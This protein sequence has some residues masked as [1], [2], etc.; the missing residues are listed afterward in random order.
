MKVVFGIL[1]ILFLAL[2][3]I[4]PLVEKYGKSYSQEEVSKISRWVLPL[5]GLLLVVQLLAF[6]FK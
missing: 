3:I 4:V 1:A 2:I 5:I 6:I